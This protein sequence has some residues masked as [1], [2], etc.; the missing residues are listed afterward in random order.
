MSRVGSRQSARGGADEATTTAGRQSQ[1]QAR[2]ITPVKSPAHAHDADLLT[3]PNGGEGGGG[4]DPNEALE[5]DAFNQEVLSMQVQ[6]ARFFSRDPPSNF[7][8]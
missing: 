4:E 2:V 5:R 7:L 8:D 3:S 6:Y 1:S